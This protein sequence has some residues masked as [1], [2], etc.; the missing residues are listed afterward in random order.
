MSQIYYFFIK[1]NIYSGFFSPQMKKRRNIGNAKKKS[2]SEK[3]D[4][5]NLQTH[6]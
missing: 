5:I 4:F 2:G 1:N 3:P 6:N